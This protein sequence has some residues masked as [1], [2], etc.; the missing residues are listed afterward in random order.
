MSELGAETAA[1]T[2]IT[3]PKV[4][5]PAEFEAVTVYVPVAVAVVGVPVILP[6]EVLMESPAGSAGAMLYEVTVPTTVGE[7]VAMAVPTV[8]VF[9]DG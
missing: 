7:S 6:V 8:N 9:G 5:L 3:T 2:V 1:L 4:R